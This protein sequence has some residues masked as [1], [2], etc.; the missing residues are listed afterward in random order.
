MKFR[1]RKKEA[2]ARPNPRPQRE[3]LPTEGLASSVFLA[4]GIVLLNV[5][6]VA[7]I[8]LLV[9]FFRGVVHYMTWIFAA[10]II[11]LFATGYYFLRRMRDEQRKLK[12]ILALPEFAGRNVEI[13]LLGGFAALR[14][15]QKKISPPTL[16]GPEGYSFLQLEAPEGIRVRDLTELGRM[17]E[18][19][20]ITREEY[21]LAKQE[22]FRNSHQPVLPE[23]ATA[24]DRVVDITPHTPEVERTVRGL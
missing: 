1:R 19:G 11:A 2:Q 24:E 10:G 13:S 6:L 12:E 5:L 16:S 4:Y 9:L 22:L 21:D 17:L 18:K 23:T 3:P 8:G 20:L 14:M 15:G 7:A